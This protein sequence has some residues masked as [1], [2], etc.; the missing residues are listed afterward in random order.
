[1]DKESHDVSC[2]MGRRMR[3]RGVVVGMGGGPIRGGVR[4][5]FE[6]LFFFRRPD[7]GSSALSS[8]L[9][10]WLRGPLQPSS[11]PSCLGS[12]M[13]VRRGY[14]ESRKDEDVQPRA[15]GQVACSPDSQPDCPPRLE[16][17]LKTHR[18]LFFCQCVRVCVFV[19]PVRQVVNCLS[20]FT[21]YTCIASSVVG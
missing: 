17:P 18:V 13:P 14:P 3:K 7:P 2:P 19:A 10:A 9:S 16:S 4:D 5:G 8:P 21:V 6:A 11:G 1:M 12:A 15:R 20:A